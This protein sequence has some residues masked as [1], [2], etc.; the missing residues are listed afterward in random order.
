MPETKQ[1]GR[2]E[3]RA[4]VRLP[5][6]LGEEVE[7]IAHEQ[8]TPPAVLLRRW[9]KERVDREHGKDGM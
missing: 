2:S 4:M 1:E 7:R 3:W 5:Q 8:L 6:D 9:I